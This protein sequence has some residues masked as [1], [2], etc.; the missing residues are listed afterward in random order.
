M[1]ATGNIL[2][3]GIFWVTIA[4][5]TV[6]LIKYTLKICASRYK[7]DVFNCCWG[8]C[9]SHRDIRSEVEIEQVRIQNGDISDNNSDEAKQDTGRPESP[10]R[11]SF[12]SI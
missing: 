12:T 11:N 4:T 9:S 10:T 5:L 3:D 8:L 7:C 1:S 6:G 2:G